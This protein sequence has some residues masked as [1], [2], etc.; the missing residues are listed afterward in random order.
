MGNQVLYVHVADDGGILVIG[1]DDGR[2]T[3]VTEAELARRVD[4]IVAA[5]G[6]LLLSRETGSVVAMPILVGIE[7]AGA[8]VVAATE[9]HPDARRT[10]GATALMAFASVGAVDLVEDLLRRGA[11]LEAR[12]EQGST[13]L[14]YAANAAEDEVVR[15]LVDAGADGDARDAEGST[16]LMFAAQRGSTRAVK[17]LLAA[18]VD[19]S[20]ARTAPDRMTAVDF[21]ESNGHARVAAILRSMDGRG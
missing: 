1:G 5:E 7:S 15:L 17:R 4:A 9:V 13:A 8:R 2:S 14:M 12:D 3:W 20:A 11:D 19:V 21:A 10:G 18:G 6:S 16:P